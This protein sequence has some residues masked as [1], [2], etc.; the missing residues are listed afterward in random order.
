[1]YNYDNKVDYAVDDITYYSIIRSAVQ[2]GYNIDNTI[3]LNNTN[4]VL[5][6]HFRPS[7]VELK[8]LP[9]SVCVESK[10]GKSDEKI[11]IYEY[12]SI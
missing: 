12:S 2:A 8:Q 6:T 5:Y 7:T 3:I 4:I 9:Y 11:Y 10:L 1:M